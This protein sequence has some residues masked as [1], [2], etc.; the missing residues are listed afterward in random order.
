MALQKISDLH[1]EGLSGRI[2]VVVADCNADITNGMLSALEK[3]FKS[4]GEGIQWQVHRV[5]GAFEIP[6]M[7]Q[8]LTQFVQVDQN[9]EEIP[10]FDVIVALG[11]VI[12]GD[13]YHFE[14]VS[15]EAARGCMQVML[16]SGTPVVFEVLACYDQEQAKL[17]SSGK[18]NHGKIA[19][20]VALDWLQK[21]K[22][23]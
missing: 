2:A 23:E 15:N 8:I 4:A 20:Q 18:H 17:R 13:T 22:G 3:V 9:D 21:L 1:F 16:E 10:L 5:P 14:L 7:A 11:C 12:K 6:L 19:A